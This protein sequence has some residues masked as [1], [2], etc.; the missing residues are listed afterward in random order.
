MKNSKH[1]LRAAATMILFCLPFLSHAQ[2]DPG[3]DPADPTCVPLDGGLAFL[4]AA[5]VGYGVKK[6]RDRRRETSGEERT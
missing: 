4:I 5:G 1:I 2:I 3:C 6:V